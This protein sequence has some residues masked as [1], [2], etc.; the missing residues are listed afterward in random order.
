M[1]WQ[2]SDPLYVNHPQESSPFSWDVLLPSSSTTSTNALSLDLGINDETRVVSYGQ[3]E[4]DAPQVQPPFYPSSNAHDEPIFLHSPHRSTRRSR[5][6]RRAR[7]Q[8]ALMLE[9][10]YPATP[11][12]GVTSL[13]PLSPELATQ[14][15]E[16]ASILVL[17]TSNR[18]RT[19][20]S[21]ENHHVRFVEGGKF[22]LKSISF[23]FIKLSYTF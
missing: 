4:P 1:S 19:R 2:S 23:S 13:P 10:E 12:I 17:P 8:N 9:V 20:Q 11:F 14:T 7:P 21:S 6:N 5:R 22:Y 15:P 16:Q 18:S 3:A